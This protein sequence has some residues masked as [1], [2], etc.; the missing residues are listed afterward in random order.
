MQDRHVESS[1]RSNIGI[2]VNGIVI[3]AQA[4][5]QRLARNGRQ[6]DYQV[7]R[8]LRQGGWSQRSLAPAP[9]SAIATQEVGGPDSADQLAVLIIDNALFEID[10]RA[11]VW[12]LV[13]DPEHFI[14]AAYRCRRL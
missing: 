6:I 11:L 14:L 3:A 1:F 2:D 5:D 7:R 13:V 12:P 4:I 10:D 9:A 8:G